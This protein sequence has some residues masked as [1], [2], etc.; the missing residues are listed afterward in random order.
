M[1]P[2]Y[3]LSVV[4]ISV[5]PSHGSTKIL[6]PPAAGTI[7]PTFTGRRSGERMMCVPRLGRI[8]GTSASLWS[9]SGRMRSAHTPVAL[10]TASA[11]IVNDS[12]RLGVA[13]LGAAGAAALLDQPGHLEPVGEHGPE[14]LGL[15]EHGQDQPHVVGLAV[16]EEVAAGGLAARPARA[17]GR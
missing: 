2:S 7:A 11:A 15:A 3:S 10:T 17:A 12:P 8:T 9:S 5:W 4:P 1:S 16:V 13:D 14:A 6:R